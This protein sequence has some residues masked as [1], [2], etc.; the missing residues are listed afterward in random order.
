M[1]WGTGRCE[2]P[3]VTSS[4][5]CLPVPTG[6][7]SIARRRKPLETGTTTSQNPNGVIVAWMRNQPRARVAYEAV[8]P[9]VFE[10]KSRA[11]AC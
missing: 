2:S 11:S 5:F 3:I 9:E 7:Q 1:L 10:A 6:R 4:V 8:T